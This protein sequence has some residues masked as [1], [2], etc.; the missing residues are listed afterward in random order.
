M[1][2]E[3]P[4][5]TTEPIDQALGALMRERHL[6]ETELAA[7]TGYNQSTISRYL[8]GDRGRQLNKETSETISGF[9]A[10]L[11][12][13]P[14][15]FVEVRIFQAWAK[16]EEAMREGLLT[17]EGLDLLVEEARLRREVESPAAS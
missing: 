5:M 16:V 15:Y 9:A 17:P 1:E 6:T 10:A 13:P 12:L 2:G 11:D 7:R 3:E 8:S 4:T 14:D